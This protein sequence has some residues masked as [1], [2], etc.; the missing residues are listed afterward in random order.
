MKISPLHVSLLIHCYAI[1]SE[2]EHRNAPAVVQYL[3]W[4]E[5]NDLIIQANTRKFGF[6]TTDRG[7]AWMQQILATPLPVSRLEWVD[8]RFAA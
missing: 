7:D 2:I 4:M 3:E 6:R 1:A 8:P 5:L